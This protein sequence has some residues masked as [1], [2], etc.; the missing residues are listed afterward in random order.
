MDEISENF[1]NLNS[2]YWI[3]IVGMLEQ[4]WA[5]ILE[6]SGSCRVYFMDDC[7]GVF[8]WID[9]ENRHV[10]EHELLDN[11]FERYATS[12]CKALVGKPM[13]D[14]RLRQHPNGRI[15]SSGRY[16]RPSRGRGDEA[17]R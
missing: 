12:A 11:D 1:K 10:A 14:F 4:N 13:G 8:D 7:N 16:W 6:K 2:D 3:K 5:L 9:F 17:G 15:Y